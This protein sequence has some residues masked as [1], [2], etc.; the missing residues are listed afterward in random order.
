[1]AFIRKPIIFDVNFYV[2]A[3]TVECDS[4]TT[5][6]EVCCHC[7]L[8]GSRAVAAPF[9]SRRLRTPSPPT[10]VLEQVHKNKKFE[11]ESG[12]SVFVTSPDGDQVCAGSR[13]ALH[14]RWATLPAFQRSPFPR[15]VA[16]AR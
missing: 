12:F 6:R 3:E 7:C 10:Q 1:M 2:G 15:L 13:P 4:Q 8:P 9:P 14:A 5:A 16:P 11:V